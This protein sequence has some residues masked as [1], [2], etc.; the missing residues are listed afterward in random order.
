MI[1]YLLILQ[2]IGLTFWGCDKETVISGGKDDEKIELLDCPSLVNINP[3]ILCTSSDGSNGVIVF[4]ECYSIQ[5]TTIIDI[6]IFSNGNSVGDTIPSAIGLLTNLT[7]LILRGA[8]RTSEPRIGNVIPPE[9][10]NLVN[11]EILDLTD[12]EFGCHKYNWLGD[13]ETDNCN[14]LCSETDE[15]NATIP[16]QIGYLTNLKGLW[17]TDNH[18]SGEIPS[19]I[20]NLV[21]LR[22]LGLRDNDL[23][24][25]IP[26]Q[27]GNLTQL[28]VF[29]MAD[30]QLGCYEY[31]FN[32]EPSPWHDNRDCCITH[33]DDTDECNGEIPSEIGNMTNLGVYKI[34]WYNPSSGGPGGQGMDY[35][36]ALNLKN[37]QLSG[38]LPSG[39]DN[40]MD[41][42]QVN[43]SYNYISGPIPP[44]MGNMTSLIILELENN[45]LNGVLPPELGNLANMSCLWLSGNNLRGQ[46]PE[47][48]CN[49]DVCGLECNN[50][51]Y[52]FS[53]NNFCPPYPEC[54]TEMNTAENT[55]N[56]V[57]N[58]MCNL[59]P[60][61][62]DGYTAFA[63]PP[64]INNGDI[65]DGYCFY[66]D[67][68]DVL[69]DIIDSNNSLKN[70]S[71]LELGE[72]T[73]Y[74]RDWNNSGALENFH[75][76]R[77]G[78]LDISDLPI[79]NFPQSIVNLDKLE[80]L[81]FSNTQ[82]SSIPSS[83]GYLTEL[84]RIY[85]IGGQL[86]GTLPSELGNLE[87][88]EQLRLQDNQLTGQIPPE[89]GN[90]TNLTFLWLQNNQL[91]GSVPF[92]LGNTNLHW[93]D[94]SKNQLTGEV[95][96]EIW[97]INA[98]YSQ[99][100]TPY[101]SQG[102]SLRRISIRENNLTGAIPENIC[103]INLR[104]RSFD[105]IDLRDNKFC[106]PY[107]S[108]LDN[109]T[110][111]QNTENCN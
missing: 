85:A 76:G 87:N 63:N 26:S 30:N 109:R 22:S 55:I 27:I 84:E 51:N 58:Q 24:G 23:T 4:G 31:D 45:E 20:G 99:S 14:E 75:H 15:C 9:I 17:L 38:S 33:C 106:P 36:P 32:C 35:W 48:L 103:D 19:S 108:C 13:W 101:E 73:W 91:T 77:L 1:R 54:F 88:L 28:H 40:L 16:N 83:I 12:N 94:L 80:Y 46:I 37:N 42:E 11:L 104:W 7:T 92:E 90:L 72:Q 34:P 52:V 79:T 5:N 71:P 69:Q 44:E 39:L 97:N 10:C 66:Q 49:I 81:Y 21:N 60:N 8:L 43:L 2:F 100:D 41:I 86:A 62:P 102:K 56:I 82:I 110:G 70:L 98:H 111:Q 95:P 25:S 65:H 29:D 107:P 61:C 67:D 74:I 96:M 53:G 6:D 50:S 105:F 47:E 59:Y 68:L 78:S 3:E 89:L 57:N 93:L 64:P 18:L